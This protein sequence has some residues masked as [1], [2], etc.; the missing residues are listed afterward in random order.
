VALGTQTCHRESKFFTQHWKNIVR[1]NAK[2]AKTN[3]QLSAD[4]DFEPSPPVTPTTRNSSRRGSSV[5]VPKQDNGRDATIAN[6]TTSIMDT[7]KSTLTAA[8]DQKANLEHQQQIQ[9]ASRMSAQ[10]DQTLAKRLAA[11]DTEHLAALK[12]KQ[13]EQQGVERTNTMLVQNLRSEVSKLAADKFE[14]VQAEL[15]QERKDRENERD[16]ANIRIIDQMTAERAERKERDEAQ[17]KR[18]ADRDAAQAKRDADIIKERTRTQDFLMEQSVT[19]Q[20]LMGGLI[21]GMAFQGR[22][23]ADMGAFFPPNLR[24]NIAHVAPASLQPQAL[25]TKEAETSPASSQLLLTDAAPNLQVPPADQQL[26]QVHPADQQMEKLTAW[27]Q[28][29]N[30]GFSPEV[31]KHLV[32]DQIGE[33][34]DLLLYDHDQWMALGF[35]GFALLKLAKLKKEAG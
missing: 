5:V 12:A 1:L 34:S 33:G 18:D 8:L 23:S 6:F 21:M 13:V 26:T 2:I 22:P 19:Q 31:L 20:H 14:K 7:V 11:K 10:N 3:R 32:D 27:L 30:V 15:I 9:E 4:S 25:L 35:K 16:K 24:A 17:A 28:A 29:H